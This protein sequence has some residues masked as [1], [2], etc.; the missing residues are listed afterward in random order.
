MSWKSFRFKKMVKTVWGKTKMFFLRYAKH[1]FNELPPFLC[2][3]FGPPLLA[4]HSKAVWSTQSCLPLFI[5]WRLVNLH[6]TQFT[7]VHHTFIYCLC[8]FIVTS[9]WSLM[10]V[11]WFDGR[12]ALSV[13]ISLGWK[14]HFNAP[15][16]A[17]GFYLKVQYWC[18]GAVW[19]WCWPQ[20]N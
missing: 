19:P 13:I 11:C 5:F 16:R 3:T 20:R 4:R 8:F 12:V 17:L 14:L 18:H 1:L 2:I 7:Y 10:S 9:L 15:I 6:C